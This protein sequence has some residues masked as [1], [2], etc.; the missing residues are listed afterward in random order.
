M[1]RRALFAILAGAAIDPEKLLWRPG[2][3]TISI[4]KQM[5][6][7]FPFPFYLPMEEFDRLYLKPAMAAMVKRWR[8]DFEAEWERDR[9]MLSGELWITETVTR[10]EALAR[11]PGCHL[12]E[13]AGA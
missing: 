2:A 11:W 9:L 3:K 6:Q 8:R 7:G 5:S 13:R 4:P 1:T 10:Q 12:P